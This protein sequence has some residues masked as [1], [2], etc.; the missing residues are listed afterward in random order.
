M[1]DCVTVGRTRWVPSTDGTGRSRGLEPF[2]SSPEIRTDLPLPLQI[3][4]NKHG[5]LQELCR[6]NTR[7]KEFKLQ[8]GS[9]ICDS[10]ES[11]DFQLHRKLANIAFV[12]VTDFKL[13]VFAQSGAHLH[14][15]TFGGIIIHV[16][17]LQHCRRC[18]TPCFQ[19]FAHG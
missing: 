16:R 6:E 18:K 10:F 7:D 13:S 5:K 4:A 11:T 12:V 15:G 17:S 8:R 3:Y 1:K 14:P 2:S 19:P 9:D